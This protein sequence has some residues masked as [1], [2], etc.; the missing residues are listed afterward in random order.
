MKNETLAYAGLIPNSP[1]LRQ[2][3]V[4]AISYLE[5]VKDVTG[6]PPSQGAGLKAFFDDCSSKC[7]SL[8][9]VDTTAPTVANIKGAVNGKTVVITYNEGLDESVTPA[10]SAYT[11]NPA[12]VVTGVLV[13]GGKVS[14]TVTTALAA[15]VT[16]AYAVPGT[17][18]LRNVSGVQAAALTATAVTLS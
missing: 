12:N 1:R 18:Q 11:L 9:L 16:I 17:N 13:Q 2:E 3:A 14:V 15:G 7:T 10:T 8:G 4:K 6:V 5:V